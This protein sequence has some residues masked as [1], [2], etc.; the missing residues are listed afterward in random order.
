MLR[1]AEDQ[2]N[3]RRVNPNAARGESTHMYGTTVDLAYSSFR[4]PA[5]P[6]LD[7]DTAGAPWLEPH[8]RRVEDAATEAGAARMSRELQAEL[9]HVLREMQSEGKVMVTMEVRQPVFHIT[10]AR[11]VLSRVGF[12]SQGA[13]RGER[14]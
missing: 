11:A 7:L 6:V 2:A 10:V 3:L 4:P 8:L 13:G 1:T 9:G 12:E 14:A 5:E